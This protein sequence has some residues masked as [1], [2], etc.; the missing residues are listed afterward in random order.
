M[1]ESRQR[2]LVLFLGA[3]DSPSEASRAA[4]VERDPGRQPGFRE[5]EP[6][7]LVSVCP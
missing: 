1:W 5:R 3:K 4:M 2:P 7:D 6:P